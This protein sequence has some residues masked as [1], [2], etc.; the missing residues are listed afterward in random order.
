V[1][2]LSSYY[3][4]KLSLQEFF[5]R[6]NHGFDKMLKHYQNILKKIYFQCDKS[7]NIYMNLCKNDDKEKATSVKKIMLH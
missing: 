1:L 3:S 2:W 7:L 5:G 6:N 4:V